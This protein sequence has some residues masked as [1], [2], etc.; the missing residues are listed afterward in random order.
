MNLL[1]YLIVAILVVVGIV[2]I[3]IFVL[4]I[5]NHH[6]DGAIAKRLRDLADD[7]EDDDHVLVAIEPQAGGPM[8]YPCP[9]WDGACNCSPLLSCQ[10]ADE[11]G[12]IT[13]PN[14][15]CVSPLPCMHSVPPVN[16]W[17]ASYKDLLP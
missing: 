10:G 13:L 7:L 11:D 5:L 17:T 12:C 4:A 1:A 15:E 14:G 16:P 6:T 2:F 8:K 3:T 9:T